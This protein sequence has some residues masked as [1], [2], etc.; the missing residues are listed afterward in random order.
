MNK[1]DTLGSK[2]E[3]KKNKE[4]NLILILNIIF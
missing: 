3:K 4:I 2:K 1:V